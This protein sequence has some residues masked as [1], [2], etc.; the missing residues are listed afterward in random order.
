MSP[1]TDIDI[2]L[3]GKG[4][5]LGCLVPLTWGTCV[6]LTCVLVVLKEIGQVEWP[7]VWIVSPLWITVSVSLLVVVVPLTLGVVLWLCYWM[8]HDE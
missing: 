6:L 8:W 4:C 5:G 2:D 1:D 3:K 7:W